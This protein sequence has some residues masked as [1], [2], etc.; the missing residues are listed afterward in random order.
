MRTA[1]IGTGMVAQLLILAVTAHGSI[2]ASAAERYDVVLGA[3]CSK[4]AA[5]SRAAT[6][7][8]IAPQERPSAAQRQSQVSPNDTARVLALLREVDEE[9]KRNLPRAYALAIQAL[10][11]AD[12]I[13][14]E[15]GILLAA[16]AS[17]F[18]GT[19]LYKLHGSGRVEEALRP[20]AAWREQR[21]NPRAMLLHLENMSRV[22]ADGGDYPEALDYHRQAMVLQDSLLSAENRKAVAEL[23]AKYEAEQR[24]REI[25]E[26]KEALAL[27]DLE[28]LRQQEELARQDLRARERAQRIMLLEKDREI[29][30]LERSRTE[31]DLEQQRSES[32]RQKQQADLLR[33]RN[34]LQAS[35]LDREKTNRNALLG[36]LAVLLI[37]AGLIIRRAQERKRAG[38]RMQKT[39]AELRRTQD[40]LIHTEKMATLG[41]MTAGIAHEIRNPMN[42]ISNFAEVT[43][44]L[45]E[46]ARSTGD[47]S[48]LPA[49]LDELN[50]A[51][52]KIATHSSRAEDIVAGMLMHARSKPGIREMTDIN[53]LVSGYVDLAWQGYRARHPGTA[54]TLTVDTDAHAGE[55]DIVPQEIA[56]V[57]LNVVQNALQAVD[58]RQRGAADGDAPAVHVQTH[59]STDGVEIRIRDSGVGIPE[60]LH[61]KIYQPFFTTKP[62]GEGTGLGL[63]MAYDIIVKGHNGGI[64]FES[65]PGEGTTFVI[66]LPL[67]DTSINDTT[68]RKPS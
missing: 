15:R 29:R 24:E 40:Q 30:G 19:S 35:L 32:A 16:R 2:S 26:Q 48:A 14:F 17:S 10:T 21:D 57:V 36:G 34:R 60:E 31:A 11:L 50:A 66:R 33:T 56:R 58:A 63:S 1:W 46:E 38:E 47:R 41:E 67:A 62:T 37:I 7:A 68:R 13:A 9:M 51:T 53:S 27:K 8:H 28:L 59:R 12:R 42:F 18:L 49:L 45:A 25:A 23:S 20:T 22:F 65:T 3:A 44:E 55:I 39:L 64:D 52:E 61:S 6:T 4:A 5:S 43:K 54:I